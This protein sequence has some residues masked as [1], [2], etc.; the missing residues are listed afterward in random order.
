MELQL[1]G[2]IILDNSVGILQ[3]SYLRFKLRQGVWYVSMRCHVPC[4]FR[5]FLPIEVSSDTFTC[6]VVSDLAFQPMWAP[7]LPRV[8]W[9]RASSSCWVEIRHCHVFLSS[10]HRLPIE[11]GSGAVMCL[12][13][14]GSASPRGVLRRCHIFLS[15]GPRLPTEVSSGAAT[16]PRSRLSERRAPVLPRTPRHP[17]GCALQ[18]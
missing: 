10:G 11:V 12:M 17:A 6:P 16:W 14:P 7:V 18:E 2:S 9:L 4:S 13:A 5:S 8:L 15:S 3:I 1:F